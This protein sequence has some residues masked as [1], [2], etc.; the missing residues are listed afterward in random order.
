MEFCRLL[1]SLPRFKRSNPFRRTAT[2]LIDQGWR[3]SSYRDDDM[4]TLSTEAQYG[5]GT[6]KSRKKRKSI[7]TRIDNWVLWRK[8]DPESIQEQMQ[9]LHYNGLDNEARKLANNP[10][11]QNWF[12]QRVKHELGRTGSELV[13]IKFDANYYSQFAKIYFKHPEFGSN[14]F[15]CNPTLKVTVFHGCMQVHGFTIASAP[16]ASYERDN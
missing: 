15:Y 8:S 10:K 12:K 7:R 3:W 13:K 6:I 5:S 4:A 9:E 14:Y 2:Y 11:F 1:A 16:K